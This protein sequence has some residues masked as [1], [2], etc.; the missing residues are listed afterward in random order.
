MA[1]MIYETPV[2]QESQ[3]MLLP[4][5]GGEY[6]RV[7]KKVAEELAGAFHFSRFFWY[8]KIM[9]SSVKIM[10]SSVSLRFV[11]LPTRSRRG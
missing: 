1:Q 2:A 10:Q 3:E 5:H 8:L 7:D 4:R 6:E 11:G 9:Q